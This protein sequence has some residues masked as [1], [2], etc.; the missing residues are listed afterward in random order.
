MEPHDTIGAV[1]GAG[2]SAASPDEERDRLARELAEA[3]EHQAATSEVRVQR[4]GRDHRRSLQTANRGIAERR[5]RQWAEELDSIRWDERPRRTYAEVEERFIREHLPTL[6]PSA[7][8]R[9]GVS[10]KNLAEH[11]GGKTLVQITSAELSSVETARR[12]DG[13][14]PATIRRDFAFLSSIL[15]SAIEWEWLDDGANP[16]P[17]YLHRRARHMLQYRE[18]DLETMS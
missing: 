6:K 10:L 13:V 9:Y 4:Q 8:L 18:P 3:L 12:A 1:R 14:T 5:A 15:R 7:A 2:P 17:P 16:V 11:F